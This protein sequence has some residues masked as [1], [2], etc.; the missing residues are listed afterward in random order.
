M[1]AFG[2]RNPWRI[3]FHPTTGELW[4]ADVGWE[5]REMIYR[6]ERGANY[7]WS[8][9]EGSQNVKVD[10]ERSSIL[11]S[12]PVFEYDHVEGRSIT[13]GYFWQ[14]DRIPELKGAYIYGDWMTGKVWA[15]KH[16]GEKVTWQNE[17]TDT[18]LQIVCF[19]NDD[20]GDV[21]VVGYDGTMWKIKS[22]PAVQQ[23]ASFNAFPRL[24][25][26]TGLFSDTAKQTPTPGVIPYSI[27]ANHWSDHSTSEQW[28]GLTGD[29]QLK[30]FDRNNWEIGQVKGF[31]SFPHDGVVAKTVS[32]RTVADDPSSSRRLETQ[33]L[34]RHEDE[35]NAYNYIWNEDQSDAILQDNIPKYSQLEVVD[36][37]Y[38]GGVRKQ[39][40]LHA[41]RDQCKLCHIWS[42]GAVHGFKVDQVNRKY[43]SEK[44]SQLEKFERLGLLDSSVRKSGLANAGPAVSCL[45]ESASLED[46]ARMY[47]DLHCAHCHRRGG[48][49]S[50]PFQ[51]SRHESLQKTNMVSPAT[52]GTFGI[53]DAQV[54]APGDPGKSVLLYRLAKHGPG[55]MPQFGNSIIDE[56]G[57]QLI[58]DWIAG[59]DSV[60]SASQFI[61]VNAQIDLLF[62]S[63]E[64]ELSFERILNN[65]LSKTETAIQLSVRCGLESDS[66]RRR[67][68]DYVIVNSRPEIRDLFERFLPDG[69]RAKRLGD[70]FS[71]AGLLAI[72]GDK[73]E[74]RKLYFGESLTCKNCHLIG[75]EGKS[76]GPVLD[77]IGIK[78]RPSEILASLTDPSAIVE[79]SYR[80]V[81]LLTSEG[82]LLTGLLG[83]KINGNLVL[84]DVEG[85]SHQVPED[86]IE[87]MRTL[88][89][90]LMPERL[91][92]ELTAQQA[93]D[94]MAFLQSL[95]T[96]S[97]K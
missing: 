2:V 51:L 97:K 32:Y 63:T 43:Q 13:G 74:G 42:A 94:L 87:E 34:H 73:E 28:I 20:D 17:L 36:P 92:N 62:A 31:F 26:K 82:T 19:A 70:N 9:V 1:W 61:P 75:G 66:L 49:G 83:E 10:G 14:S 90:S 3:A 88:E 12:K 4:A 81:V 8:V 68:T 67:V 89:K 91:L 30:L 95:K 44:I 79:D 69:Q 76:V 38:P 46:R 22:N 45:D 59:M 86:D 35:W 25:S 5:M 16:D 27:N 54:I 93:A 77:D 64:N 52:Q 47:L 96:P 48:G 85:K 39:K 55:R 29:S 60:D 15:L 78:R 21:L 84:I 7:G 24:L 50:A 33:I 56:A 71:S 57:V 11:I 37:D 41:S 40:W 53:D 58:H 65:L 18:P 72:K 6:I 80:G 23:Q